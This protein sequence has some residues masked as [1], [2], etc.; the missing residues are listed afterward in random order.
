[1]SSADTTA[2]L[3]VCDVPSFLYLSLI[4]THGAGRVVI[5][6]S[7]V[8]D[9][10]SPKFVQLGGLEAPFFLQ[11]SCLPEACRELATQLCSQ[12]GRSP[13]FWSP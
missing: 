8:W 13:G 7:H 1:M 11:S 6:S 3:M 10:L 5:F 12:D 9:H 4:V 2:H